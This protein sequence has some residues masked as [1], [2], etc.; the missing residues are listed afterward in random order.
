MEFFL[1]GHPLNVFAQVRELTDNA[2]R[3]GNT[4]RSVVS[5]LWLYRYETG[6]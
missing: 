1:N 2:A 6:A 4:S 5:L 3:G